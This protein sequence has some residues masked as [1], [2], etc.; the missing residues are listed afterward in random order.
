VVVSLKWIHFIILNI[1]TQYS[2]VEIFLGEYDIFF[3][4]CAILWGLDRL[5]RF[6]RILILNPRFWKKTA[7]VSY[8]PDSN[9]IR[10]VAE[11][12]SGLLKSYPGAFY[13]IYTLNH[14]RFWESHPFTLAYCTTDGDAAHPTLKPAK[15]PLV[16]RLSTSSDRSRSPAQSTESDEL[17]GSDSSSSLVFLIRPYDGF[18]SR[19]K[20]AASSTPEPLHV[21]LEGPYGESDHLSAFQNILLI[22]GGSGI[23]VPLSVLDSLLHNEHF[24]APSCITIVWAVRE[25]EFC[26]DVLDTDLRLCVAG[27]HN[28]KL[29]VEVY[30][31]KGRNDAE[32]LK[33]Y[34]KQRNGMDVA[35]FGRRP[36]IRERVMGEGMRCRG[37]G[38][39]LAVVACGPAGMADE[40][41]SSVVEVLRKGEGWDGIKFFD[42]GFSW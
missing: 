7:T 35:V 38:E 28:A 21:L 14:L 3:W 2:H 27:E 37:E 39:K 29:S 16:Q 41:R 22:V 25:P 19:L 13:Y 30:C 8:N 12:N 24:S 10:V 9:I 6:S 17:L 4:P 23:A 26:S 33:E 36:D 1:L 31:T 20:N 11:T 42:K 34:V 18:T 40:V 5:L 32:A 15:Q